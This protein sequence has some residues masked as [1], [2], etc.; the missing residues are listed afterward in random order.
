VKELENCSGT[1]F[2]PEIVTCFINY[3]DE[4]WL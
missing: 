3:I 2:D 1:Q 4:K